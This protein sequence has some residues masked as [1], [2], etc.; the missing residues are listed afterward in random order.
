MI[1]IFSKIIALFLFALSV[2]LPARPERVD[3]SLET[4]EESQTITVFW[5]N[6]TNIFRS[7]LDNGCG[8]L[9]TLVV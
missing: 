5:E 1:P 7:R 8:I 4:G 3:I 6:N 2:F 9:Y